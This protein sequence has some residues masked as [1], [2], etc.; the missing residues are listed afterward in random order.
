M[1]YTTAPIAAVPAAL[2]LTTK[3]FKSL[4]L[5]A[6]TLSEPVSIFTPSSIF[7]VIVSF[8]TLATALPFTDAVPDAPPPTDIRVA[9]LIESAA[10]AVLFSISNLEPLNIFELTL[11]FPASTNTLAPTDALPPYESLPIIAFVAV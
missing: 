3:P 6:L 10:T 2:A 5:L 9:F 7:A 11:E 8:I 1:T 4:S